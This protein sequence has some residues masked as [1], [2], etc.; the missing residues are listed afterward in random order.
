[1]QIRFHVEA[2]AELNAARLWYGLQRANL[3]SVFM[4]RVEEALARILVAPY[5]Y[6]SRIAS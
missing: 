4:D 1:M 2:E 3:G 6:Q 5:S